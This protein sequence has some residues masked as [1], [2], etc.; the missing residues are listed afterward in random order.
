MSDLTAAIIGATGYTG[1]E[2]A[3]LIAGHPRLRVTQMTSRKRASKPVASVHPHLRGVDLPDFTTPDETSPVDVAFLCLPHGVAAGELG[4]YT[5]RARVVVD[6]SADHRLNDNETYERWYG[7]PH[8]DP[9]NLER[10]VYGLPELTRNQLP[11]A[12]LISGVGCN[13]TSMI[14]ALRPLARA[15]LVDRVICD[16]KVGSSEAGAEPSAGS[17]HP[18][19]SRVVRTYAPTSHRHAAEVHQACPELSQHNL[20]TTI[21]AVE[22]VRGVLCAAH[23]LPTENVNDRD[24]WSIYREA[25]QN[26]PFVRFVKSRGGPHRWPEPRHL[27][28][29][30]FAEIGWEVDPAGR[31]VV[32]A[33]IDNLTKGAAGSALQS[34]NIALGCEE[35]DGLHFSG[36]HPV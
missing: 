34:A 6:L 8:P 24:L 31:I 21:S 20:H 33:A 9:A 17:H 18:E 36:M 29:T 13:A 32:L 4:R 2:L 16:I 14:L 7:V 3:R 1:G 12:S 27:A 5:D 35:T 26:E 11:D 30:N 28:G 19:R 23:I 25:Y 22:M 15:G 10:A